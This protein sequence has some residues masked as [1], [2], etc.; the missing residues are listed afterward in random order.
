VIREPVCD[1]RNL[2]RHTLPSSP[3]SA[4]R[5]T[6]SACAIPLGDHQLVAAVEVIEG[7]GQLRAADMD[8]NASMS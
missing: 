3:R 4:S 7:G 6:S 8:G 5:P 1:G 2:R